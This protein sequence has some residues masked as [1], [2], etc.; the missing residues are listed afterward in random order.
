MDVETTRGG[1]ISNC[2]LSRYCVHTA[3]HCALWHV[4]PKVDLELIL[5]LLQADMTSALCHRGLFQ[6]SRYATIFVG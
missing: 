3:A 1:R 4:Y 5:A 2:C 6:K